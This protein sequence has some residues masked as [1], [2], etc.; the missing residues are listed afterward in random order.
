MNHVNSRRGRGRL[1][2]PANPRTLA[3]PLVTV[4]AS[5]LTVVLAGCTTTAPFETRA[6]AEQVL[7][8]LPSSWAAG[9]GTAETETAE[10]TAEMLSD[11]PALGP[12][13][14]RLLDLVG[15]SQ[16]QQLVLEALEAN[17]DLRAA[18]YRLEASRR[19]LA[20]TR[21]ARSP[22]V[23]A[24]YSA[25]R[26]NQGFDAFGGPRLETRH[27][28][29]LDVSWEIDLWRRIGDLHDADASLASA[30]AAD[31][32]AARDVLGARV[33]QAW[34]AAVALRQ[35]IAVE[36]QRI[37]VLERLQTTITRRYRRGLG[38]LED[39]AAARSGTELARATVAGLEDDLEQTHRALEL[40]LGRVPRD[41]LQSADTLPAIAFGS[42]KV[43]A[44]VLARRPDVESALWRL[45]AA[46]ASAAAAA[47]ALLPRLQLRGELVREAARAPDLASV[48]TLWSL[49]GAV[50]QPIFQRGL[51]RARADAGRLELEAALEEY[52]GVVLR[53]VGEV[54]D[55]L[56][57]QRSLLRQRHHVD[58]A[59]G[60]AIRTS[61]VFESRYRAGLASILELLQA[62]N[63]RLDIHRQLLAVNGEI[64]SHRITLALAVGAGFEELES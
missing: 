34:V 61:S 9:T 27:R 43:P 46:D 2:P 20:E 6:A 3:R 5:V 24:G 63:Q 50:T 19:L 38:S 58:R 64:L 4:L 33:V 26:S 48:T 11:A 15:D 1:G 23:A 13:S 8:D 42:P 44:T 31:L 22:I 7:L 60:E 62:E 17:H 12:L 55:A 30:Q 59:L 39:L 57:R 54:E 28:V 29:A 40:L 14:N 35:A 56:G 36:E 47:K 45:R 53:A 21:A 37:Q 32:A 25:G 51:L 41:E 49:L 18:A 52:R 16:L 10:A